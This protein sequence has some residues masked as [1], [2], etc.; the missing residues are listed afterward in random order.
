MAF[1]NRHFGAESDQIRDRNFPHLYAVSVR[2]NPEENR[3]QISV[4]L[5]IGE[6]NAR[7]IAQTPY[8]FADQEA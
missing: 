1:S 3:M 7:R 6:D 2:H 5:D 4:L 8:L